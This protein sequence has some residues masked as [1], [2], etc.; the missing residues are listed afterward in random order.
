MAI[1]DWYVDAMFQYS[2]PLGLL[3]FEISAAHSMTLLSSLSASLS[4]DYGLSVPPAKAAVKVRPALLAGRF[5]LSGMTQRWTMAYAC[6]RLGRCLC[7]TSE[8]MWQIHRRAA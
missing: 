3:E 2:K 6:L 8:P 4:N 7:H 5:T 1:S